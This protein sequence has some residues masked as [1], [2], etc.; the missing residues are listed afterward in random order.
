MSRVWK[1]LRVATKTREAEDIA[2]FELVDP[3]GGPL[4]AF[5]AGAHIDLEIAPGL[6]RQYSL[7]NDPQEQRRYLIGVLRDPA[8]RGG[9]ITLV[10]TIKAGTLLRVSGPR[11]HFALDPSALRVVLMAGG[12]GITPILC[13]AEH[14]AHTSIPFEL[15][16][17]IRSRARAAFLDRISGST[18]SNRARI[19]FGGTQESVRLDLDETLKRRGPE[20][21]LYVCGPMGFI[22]SVLGRAVCAGWQPQQLHREFFMPV[23]DGPRSND[24]LADDVF[25]VEI[26][27]TGARFTVPA[28][29][30]VLDVLRANRIDIPT[31]CEQGVC[32]ACIT[33]V[34]RGVPE[35]RDRFM[36]DE[37]HARN[38]QFAPCCSRSKSAPLLLDL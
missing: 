11:N 36:T 10:D 22:E 35:H 24:V 29:R 34:L 16:Y 9:S 1:T 19:H 20:D 13:M 18:F 21:H 4:P 5:S 38:D 6:V 3:R 31:S 32:G 7:C 2:S 26:S 12:I 27:S 15:H 37:E 30:S 8:S 17:C 33:G 14:L 25:E 23:A 28:D